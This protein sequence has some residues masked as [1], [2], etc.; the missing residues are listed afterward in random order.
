MSNKDLN[1]SLRALVIIFLLTGVIYLTPSVNY[2]NPSISLAASI[3]QVFPVSGQVII[4]FFDQ[5]GVSPAKLDGFAKVKTSSPAPGT[6]VIQTEILEMEL[7]GSIRIGNPIVLEPIRIRIGQTFG[8][9][10]ST[11]SVIPIN[12]RRDFPAESFFDVFTE[13]EV[14]GQLLHNELPIPMKGNLANTPAQ[15]AFNIDFTEGPAQSDVFGTD[16]SLVETAGGAEAAYTGLSY[17]FQDFWEF[18]E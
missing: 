1:F 11:G 4:D 17:V 18:L 5:P 15:A 7:T 10:P 12:P 9:P 3:E 14:G 2:Q 13:V 8:L 6:G 16:F